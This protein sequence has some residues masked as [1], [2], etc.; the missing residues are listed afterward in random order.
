MIHYC[1][2]IGP[3]LGPVRSRP[4]ALWGSGAGAGVLPGTDNNDK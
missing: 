1:L 3:G 4:G 2:A